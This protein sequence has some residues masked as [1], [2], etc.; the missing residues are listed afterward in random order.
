MFYIFGLISKYIEHPQLSL[1][2][3]WKQSMSSFT[4]TGSSEESL[5]LAI[6]ESLKSFFLN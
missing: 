3:K 1:L 4:R 2:F 6:F 5:G